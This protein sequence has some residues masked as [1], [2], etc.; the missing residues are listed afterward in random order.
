MESFE[1]GGTL[2][3]KAAKL[4]EFP[5]MAMFGVGCRSIAIEI[6]GVSGGR[7]L[8]CL[9]ERHFK[10]KDKI[11]KID[12]SKYRLQDYIQPICLNGGSFCAGYT[13]GTSRLLLNYTNIRGWVGWVFLP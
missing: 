4:Y 2:L 6:P 12:F 7:L 1:C 5:W 11:S 9:I 13:N 10:T 3:S 8:N